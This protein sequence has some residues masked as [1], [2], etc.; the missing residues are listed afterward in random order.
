M[1]SLVLRHRAMVVLACLGLAAG[2]LLRLSRL[3]L[4][5]WPDLSPVQ[6]QILTPVPDLAAPEVETGITRMLEIECAGLPQ[7]GELRSVSTFGLSQLTL[8]FGDGTDPWQ[9]RQMTQERIQNALPRLPKG[10][11]PRLGPPSDA[12]GEVAAYALRYRTGPMSP[13]RL[14]DLKAL[15]D[16]V[17]RPRLL[18]VPGVVEVNATGGFDRQIVVEP[19]PQ[20]LYAAGLDVKDLAMALEQSVAIGGGA[21]L[22]VNGEQ[23]VIRSAARAQTIADLAGS[24]VRL[25]WG[26]VAINVKDLATVREGEKVRF[27]AGT[28]DGEEAVLG[29]VLLGHHG[30]ATATAR[31]VKARLRELPAVL[32]SDVEVVPLYNRAALTRG[33]LQTAGR[34]LAFAAAIVTVVLWFFFRQLKAALITVTVIP[35]AF[36]FGLAASSLLGTSG[37]LMSLGAIDLGLI[38]DGAVVVVD[39]YLLRLGQARDAGTT[40]SLGSPDRF[41]LAA[42]STREVAGPMAYGWLVILVGYTPAFFLPGLDRAIF[43]PMALTA[44][45]ALLAALPL[46]LLLVPVLAATFLR[47]PPATTALAAIGTEKYLGLLRWT[48][49]HRLVCLAFAACLCL[50]GWVMAGRLG[51]D[52]L[53]PLDEGS[54]VLEVEKPVATDLEA[55]LAGEVR[56]ERLLRQNFP[57]IKQAYSRLGFS[58][59][60]TDPQAPNQNDIYVSYRPRSEWP[61][62]EGRRLTK[63]ELERR[64]LANLQAVFQDHEFGLN[65]PI[66]T[67]LDE[68]LE[69]THADVAVELLGLNL[70]ALN[71]A[72]E[73]VAQVL[74]GVPGA[75]DVL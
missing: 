55:S 34:N 28:L 56:A 61:L 1:V 18:T 65:Q 9:A 50:T 52:L 2:A 45:C 19:D 74:K 70:D 33:V 38:V 60:A 26:S 16:F 32:P 63:T 15:Q 47:Q 48:R 11:L 30:D 20:K 46:S 66:R 6:V 36:L 42:Q 5:V 24:S 71:E 13:Q 54:T 25:S 10:C 57:E 3:P 12:V 68:M 35:L 49:R 21:F 40:G 62:R 64:F 43:G 29:T 7:L 4:D 72:A 14:A 8:I 59:V 73:K 51:F 39:N 27:G 41:R 17:V 23:R 58:D 44:V 37:N 53:P 22:G 31:Q 69:G 75:T 67:R